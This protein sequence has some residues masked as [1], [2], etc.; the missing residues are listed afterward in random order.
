[1]NFFASSLTFGSES[2]GD[3]MSS[4]CTRRST[5]ERHV[6]FSESNLGRFAAGTAF[7]RVGPNGPVSLQK[8]KNDINDALVCWYP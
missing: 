1:M 5:S 2:S 8:Q 7:E 3:C 4:V 6:L